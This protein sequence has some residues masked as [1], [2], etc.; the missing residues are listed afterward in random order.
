MP[1]AAAL[2]FKFQVSSCLSPAL[3]PAA[4]VILVTTRMRCIVILNE[5]AGTAAKASPE[6]VRAACAAAGIAAEVVA[7]PAERIERALREAVASRPDAVAI[8]GGDGTV[9][10]A[11]AALA[12]T[13]LTLGV[14]P[15]GT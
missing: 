12:D 14:L 1:Q 10:C 5:K 2:Q 15:L 4:G 6:A 7:L 3:R 11:A 8:G 13:G 9:R